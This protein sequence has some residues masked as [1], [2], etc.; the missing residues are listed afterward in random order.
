MSCEMCSASRS[1]ES[2]EV[3]LNRSLCFI[4]GAPW[5]SYGVLQLQPVDR[6]A[7]VESSL[8]CTRQAT[9]P[10]TGSPPPRRQ[11]ALGPSGLAW[12]CYLAHFAVYVEPEDAGGGHAL[13]RPGGDCT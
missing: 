11:A 13:P 9:N 5:E 10:M 4:G 12:A 6:P 8:R 3:T 1:T 2:I 7:A